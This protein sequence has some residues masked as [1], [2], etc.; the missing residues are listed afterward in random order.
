MKLLYLSIFNTKVALYVFSFFIYIG[1]PQFRTNPHGQTLD[2][3]EK[4]PGKKPWETL[5]CFFILLSATLS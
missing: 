3:S 5:E 2:L 4:N 1:H